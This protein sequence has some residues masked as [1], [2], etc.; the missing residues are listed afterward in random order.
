M[1]LV[2]YVPPEKK[3]QLS[4]KA[5]M[6]HVVGLYGGSVVSGDETTSAGGLLYRFVDFKS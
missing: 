5:W 6:E 4:A 1:A 3:D 2:S